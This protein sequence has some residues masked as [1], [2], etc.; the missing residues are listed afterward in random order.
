[1]IDFNEYNRL[2]NQFGGHPDALSGQFGK[3]YW[4]Y[5]HYA[6]FQ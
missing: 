3:T 2:H 6:Q 5:Y 4:F 1:V